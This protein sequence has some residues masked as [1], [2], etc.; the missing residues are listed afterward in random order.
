[1][2]GGEGS[3]LNYRRANVEGGY[4]FLLMF[5]N[6]KNIAKLERLIAAREG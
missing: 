6:L 2:R 4:K 3:T 1:M 5:T